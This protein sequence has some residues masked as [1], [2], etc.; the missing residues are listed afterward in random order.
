[1]ED[2]PFLDVG[3][4]SDSDLV[5]VSAE[6]GTVPNGGAIPNSDLPGENNVGG[7]VSIDSNLGQPLSQG[8]DPALPAVVPL[9]AIRHRRR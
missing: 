4:K 9:H 2:A 6:D 3:A 8:D 5:K 1:M 7:D